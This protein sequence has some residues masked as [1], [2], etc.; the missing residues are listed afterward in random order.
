MC[1]HKDFG[2]NFY[3]S[4]LKSIVLRP[5]GRSRCRK[6][7][8][9][10]LNARGGEGGMVEKRGERGRGGVSR[11]L[12]SVKGEEKERKEKKKSLSLFYA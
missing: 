5:P 8:N 12:L 9:G 10:Y 3:D 7:S 4:L 11:P 1:V 6:N 2:Q